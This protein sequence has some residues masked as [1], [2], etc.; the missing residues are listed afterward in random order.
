MTALKHKAMATVAIE[1]LCY[2]SS[3]QTVRRRATVMVVAV[4]NMPIQQEH[5]QDFLNQRIIIITI[6]NRNAK[7]RNKANVNCSWRP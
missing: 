1:L 4:T 7:I 6:V 3:I 2:L 5:Q